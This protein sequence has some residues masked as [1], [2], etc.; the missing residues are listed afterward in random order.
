[1]KQDFVIALGALYAPEQMKKN[2]PMAKHTSFKAGGCADIFVSP[3]DHEQLKRTIRLCLRF[4]MPYFVIGNGSNI[5]VRDK[6]F[7]GVVI[8]IDKAM[9]AVELLAD[10]RIKAEAGAQLSAVANFALKQGLA[11]FEFAGGIPGTVGGAVYMN[12]GAYGGEMKDVFASA[13][14]MTAD[15][16]I[17]TITA[18]EIDF[19]YRKSKVQQDGLI[20]LSCVIALTKGD[21]EAIKEKM[22]DFSRRRADKQPLEKASAGSTFKRPEGHFAGK[23]IMDSGL[24]GFQIGAAQVSEKHCGFVINNGGATA[25]DILNLMTHVRGVVYQNYGVTLEPEVR[26]IGEE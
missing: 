26:I 9:S 14:V 24:G 1:M 17:R 12:A 15:G 21:P 22:R 3:A 20:V 2:E 4:G 23:L 25:A 13:E 6:G 19:G 11:G 5:L 7:R 8:S 18:D 16:A 10:D